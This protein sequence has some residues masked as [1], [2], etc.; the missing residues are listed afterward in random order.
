MEQTSNNQSIFYKCEKSYNDVENK[1]EYFKFSLFNN[2]MDNEPKEVDLN[3]VLGLL[4]GKDHNLTSKINELRTLSKDEYTTKKKNLPAVTFQGTFT[5]RKKDHIKQSNGLAV[6]DYDNLENPEEKK[7]EVKKDPYT[8]MAFTSPSGKGIKVVCK[9]DKEIDNE[10]Y[11]K[12]YRAL[13]KHFGGNP[14]NTI[15]ISRLCFLTVDYDYYYNPESEVF[16]EKQEQEQNN[17][18]QEQNTQQQ[19]QEISD[20]KIDKL[21]ESFFKNF[22]EDREHWHKLREDFK[23]AR[24]RNNVFI[25]NLASFLKNN[26]DY[27]KKV[28]DF[29]NNLHDTKNPKL[30]LKGFMNEPQIKKL[31]YKELK[32]WVEK[33]NLENFKKYLRMPIESNNPIGY[34]F[35]ITENTVRITN[36]VEKEAKD[37]N[38]NKYY[39]TNTYPLLEFIEFYKINATIYDKKH[40]KQRKELYFIRTTKDKYLR[41]YEDL[42]KELQV[43]IKHNSDGGSTQRIYLQDFILESGLLDNLTEIDKTYTTHFYFNQQE[44][45]FLIPNLSNLPDSENVIKCDLIQQVDSKDKQYLEE[46]SIQNLDQ[47]EFYTTNEDNNKVEEAKK[48]LE[49]IPRTQQEK[50]NYKVALSY[51]LASLLNNLFQ[52]YFILGSI[53]YVGVGKTSLFSVCI[54]NLWKTYND[55]KPLTYNK[56]K[57]EKDTQME[58]KNILPD[59]RPP[60]TDEVNS[61]SDIYKDILKNKIKSETMPYTF[62]RQNPYHSDINFINPFLETFTGNS[63]S[64]DDFSDFQDKFLHLDFNDLEDIKETE[65]IKYNISNYEMEKLTNDYIK[66]LGK[67]IY[68]ELIKMDHNQELENLKQNVNF[69]YGR[70]E[71]HLLFLKYGEHL[72]NK[73]GLFTDLEITREQFQQMKANNHN[74]IYSQAD[75]IRECIN[76]LIHSMEYKCSLDDLI[77]LRSEGITNDV[78]LKF[79]NENLNNKGIYLKMTKEKVELVFTSNFIYHLN[80]KYQHKTR[81]TLKLKTKRDLFNKLKEIGSNGEIKQDTTQRGIL[82][83]NDTKRINEYK[84]NEKRVKG[85]AISLDLIR[86]NDEVDKEAEKNRTFNQED[87]E[88]KEDEEVTQY[89]VTK[90]ENIKF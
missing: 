18:L 29:L 39:Y 65:G 16:H 55:I 3:Y 51:S 85:V 47:S 23:V 20:I 50:L 15:D 88:T 72:L 52:E 73:F 67:Y 7:E 24:E 56:D 14:D 53:G 49:N 68:N 48:L 13:Q 32:N 76:S 6:L 84:L 60:Y 8:F 9:I 63:L 31:I 54:G 41:D 21:A 43:F 57:S 17:S 46:V 62:T 75:E 1:Q 27:E 40:R 64:F 4:G 42:I 81:K 38:G 80:E 70:D 61:I 19:T 74:K 2:A 45:K 25:K 83:L 87:D 33:Y 78:T 10:E 34:N 79:F 37:E 44:G 59:T 12:R 58:L 90:I 66:H 28:Y 86:K 77:R 71:N 82:T 11:A 69:G 22:L 89:Q 26:S 35:I 5:K 36:T 30:Q